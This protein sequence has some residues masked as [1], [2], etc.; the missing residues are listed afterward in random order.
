MLCINISRVQKSP[1]IC[2]WSVPWYQQKD[3]IVLFLWTITLV[4]PLFSFSLVLW[5]DSS[6]HG[7]LRLHGMLFSKNVCFLNRNRN[8]RQFKIT[9][10]KI[11]TSWGQT[12]FTTD[13]AVLIRRQKLKV[14]V[15]IRNSDQRRG[16][17]D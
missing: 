17:V 15:S 6:N 2:I 16:C 5:S 1:Y 8:H 10:E 3:P 13:N 7:I 11:Y 12:L 9:M 14:S 4:G